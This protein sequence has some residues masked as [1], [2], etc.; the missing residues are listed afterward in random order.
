MLKQIKD[1]FFEESRSIQRRGWMNPSV[2]ECPDYLLCCIM[3]L[4]DVCRPDMEKEKSFPPADTHF[5]FSAKVKFQIWD[6]FREFS[7]STAR[8]LD[9]FSM[10]DPD[11]SWCLSRYIRIGLACRLVLDNKC[12]QLSMWE[13]NSYWNFQLVKE[14]CI[15]Y[16]EI[17]E[18]LIKIKTDCI[19]YLVFI[20]SFHILLHFFW[21]TFSSLSNLRT[22][23]NN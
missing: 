9:S 10:S 14:I 1:F 22:R 6:L 16:I 4:Q 13:N 11:I 7:A 15:F 5:Q 12:K 18:K 8:L 19:M 2:P 20:N 23:E 21:F 17:F 3:P